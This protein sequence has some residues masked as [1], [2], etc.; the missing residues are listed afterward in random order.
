MV[1][2]KDEPTQAG[3]APAANTA[4]VAPAIALPKG[5]GAIRGIGEKFAANL[6]TGTAAMTV[7][8]ATSP[9]RAG[10][11]PRLEL[12]YD[13]GVGNG[14]FG[15]GWTLSLP[16]ITRKTD[17]GLPQYA[18]HD[19]L[20]VFLL[21]GAEDLAPVLVEAGGKWQPEVLPMRTVGG[22][23]YRIRRY[24]PRVEGLF[25][26]IE[27]W[28]NVANPT[29]TFWRSISKDN[30][31]TW[32]GRTAESRIADP[33]DATRI[34][35]W[36]ICESHD[37]RGNAIAYR[38]KA[39]NG[40]KVNL[41]AAH[42]QNRGP[43]DDA[44]RTANRYLKR[45]RYGNHTPYLPKL[46]GDQAWP[47][48][49]SDDPWY[50]EVVFDYGE[51]TADTAEETGPWDARPDAFSSYRSTFEVRTARLCQRVLM[52]HHIPDDPAPGT[53]KGYDGLVRS[54]KFTYEYEQDPQNARVPV[55]SK[56]V[57]ASQKGWQRK[58]GGGY[59]VAALPPVE[60]EYTDAAIG[61]ELRELD[62]ASAENLPAGIGGGYQWIDL[63]GEGLSGVLTEQA[64]GWFYKRNL[65][66]L[67]PV[68]NGDGA[69]IEAKLAPLELVATK[70]GFGLDG[71]TQFLDLAGDGRPDAV[72]FG[73]ATPGFYE[74]TEDAG[75]E[76]F[77]PFAALPAV[78]WADPNLKFLDM[79]G[80]GH[81]DLL[82]S[83]QDA[84]V[85]HRSLGEAGFDQAQRVSK[86]WDEERGPHLLFAD[87]EQSV[88]LAD[89]SGDG[90]TDIVRVRNGEVCYWPNL[91]YGRF[92]AKI[93]MDNSPL[94]DRPEQFDQR[95]VRLAD[96]DGSG[97]TD[98][99]YLHS[100]GVRVYFNQSGNNWSGPTSVDALP[101]LDNVAGVQVLDLLG[102][103]TACLVWSSP[104]PGDAPRTLRYLDLLGGEKPHLLKKVTNNLGG[105]T[106]ISYAASTKFYLLDRDAGRPWVTKLPFPVHCVERVTVHDKW[107]GT[108]FTTTYSYHHG[109][110]DGAEREFRGFGRVEQVDAEAYGK[111]AEGNKKSPF[112][113][114]DL[115]LYQP[116]VKTVTW[117]HT[118]A[119]LDRATILGHYRDEYFPNGFEAQMPGQQVLG[120]FRE[121]A[122]PEPDLRGADLTPD[123]WREA[124]RA[125]K[126][127]VL[128]QEIYE[129]DVDAHAKGEEK[130]VKLFSAAEH[131]CRI[132]RL[133]PQGP[134]PHAVFLVTESEALT[135][136]YELD[137]C[138]GGV[139]LETLAPDPRISHT[140]NLD[141]DEYGNIRQ[142]VAAAY[143][144]TGKLVDPNLKNGSQALAQHVQS[145][146]H[147]AYTETRYTNDVSTA[148]S[149]DRDSHRLRLP[150]EVRTYE[151]TGGL[152][153]VKTPE[154]NGGA[155]P[156]AVADR[157]FTP[158]ELLAYRLSERYQ[159]AG[160]EVQELGYHELPDGTTVQK[161]LVEHARSLFFKESLDGPEPF[162][163]LNR[164]ALP[165]ESYKLALTG[166][167]LDAV[168]GDKLDAPVRAA[169]GDKAK[170]GYLS[171]ND[172]T[173]RLGADTA[174]QFWIC[175]GVAGFNADAADHFYLPEHYTDPF[176]NP[177]LL[178]YDGRDL[179][180]QSST[181]ALG[182][183]TEVTDFDFRVLRPRRLK[184]INGNFSEVRF[185]VLGMPAALAL[186][187][188]GLVGPGA[189]GDN[190][191]GLDDASA[192]INPDG[193]NRA[194]FF[195]T[196]D[197]TPAA[198]K[199]FLQGATARHLYYFGEVHAGDQVVWGQHP[200]CAAGIR[201]EQH[202]AAN[203]DSPV[204]TAFEYSD[205][206]GNP[207]VKKVQAE[208]ATPGG[209]LRWVASGKTVLNN[210][211]KPVKQFEPAFSPPAIGHRYNGEEAALETGVTLVTYYDAAGRVVRT[212]A[213]DG[214][215]T[216]VEFSPW[217]VAHFD[218]N[219]TV[220]EDGNA[221]FAAKSAP[222]APAADRRAA[223]LAAGHANTP[224][225][226]VLDSLGR[227]VL[228]IS[229]NRTGPAAAP[230]DEKLVTFSKLDA[231]GK[232]LWVQDARGNRV[233]QYLRPPLPEGPKAFD[234]PQNLQPQGF[235]PCY[236]IAGNLLFQHGMD[237][238][239]R[240]MLNDAAGKPIYAWNSRGFISHVEYDKLHRPTGSFVT[241]TGDTT[242]IGSPRN[243]ALPPDP[244]RQFEKIVYGED[245]AD[246]RKHNLRGK[247]YQQRDAAGVMTVEDY[248]FKGNALSS[249]REFVADYKQTPDW[250]QAAPL[251]P[252]AFVT[253]TQFDALGRPVSITTPDGSTHRPHFNEASLLEKVEVNLRGEQEAGAPKWTP[254]VT[255]IDYNAKAQRERIEYANGATTTYEY[256]PQTFRLIHLKTTR[257]DDPDATASALFARRDTVQDLR[258][259]YDP[260]G[261][262]TRIADR[263]H[264]TV[265]CDNQQIDAASDYA[266]DALYRLIAASGRERAAA[267][268]YTWDDTANRI[269]M[270]PG[271]NGA[272]GC[273]VETYE[274][275]A[276]GNIQRMVHHDGGNA[277][278][279]GAVTW[280]R[281]Y[282]YD[283]AN[284]RLLATS[285]PGDA[286]GVFGAP[287]AYDSHGNTTRMSH[288]PLMRW[289]F[290][291]Q[292]AATSQQ[293]V[294]AGTPETTYYVYDGAG[295]R[296]RKVT[297]RQAGA[298]QTPARSKERIYLGGCE[299]YREYGN[300]GVG[301]AR[302]T[303]HVMDDK[304]R[305]ALVET[306]T[307]ENG[308]PI[309]APAPAV[310]YQLANHLGSGSLELDGQGQVISYEEYTP[311]GSTAY[312]AARNA[313]E[314]S[315]KR[316]RYTGKERDEETGFTYHG[317]R[318][319][320]PW[321]GRWVSCDPIGLA[322][323]PNLYAYVGN[324]P[325]NKTDPT[326]QQEKKEG[327]PNKKTDPVE[328]KKY[329]PCGD[330]L[331][332]GV[333]DCPS[334]FGAKNPDTVDSVG[335]PA[336][337]MTD[338]QRRKEGRP[339]ATAGAAPPEEARQGKVLAGPGAKEL[340]MAKKD[341]KQGVK[342][343]IFDATIGRFVLTPLEFVAPTSETTQFVAGLRP[344]TNS[345]IARYVA[346]ATS[347]VA[348]I[349]VDIALSAALQGIGDQ[350]TKGL[351]LE[352]PDAR[353]KITTDGGKPTVS[354]G[355]DAPTFG[356]RA[357]ASPTPLNPLELK[358]G[359]G[360][361]AVA[362]TPGGPL[363]M[364][365]L[366]DTATGVYQYRSATGQPLSPHFRDMFGTPGSYYATHAEAKAFFLNP[367]AASVT[368]SKPPCIG[369]IQ[370]FKA[371]SQL[372]NRPIQIHAPT[373]AG[374][375][376]WTFQN[377]QAWATPFIGSF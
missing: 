160:S 332:A 259:T 364:S 126:G 169:L 17:K 278:L 110:F 284:N 156:P 265:F 162:G 213:P 114:D 90:L 326:G 206:M 166:P 333:G 225:V 338:E 13:S 12:A 346:G 157:Y 25:A 188:K 300:G 35:S 163:T 137:L 57:S 261:N 106:E 299:F 296:V 86:P 124:L 84:F 82:I 88:Y 241:A 374:P 128:R 285:L 245:Q 146:V 228:Q 272:L 133:Q 183:R 227:D 324:G 97:T 159:A 200:P 305:I 54:T 347:Q 28:T 85:W 144:R 327:D 56:L 175:S 117:Y 315:L 108:R 317:A 262:I 337:T 49:P 254:F 153:G 242:L 16:A 78:D 172:L 2:V 103:G 295:Q 151:L 376:T 131:N 290:R 87:R 310:R 257:P 71:G 205:G 220:L 93:T 59:L 73:G 270:P 149:G 20:D 89:V 268:Q 120:D 207:L 62:A 271:D 231:E 11:G 341:S 314:V 75:W 328:E 323:G 164:L 18:D 352:P 219:D 99:L 9:G 105:E 107:R 67:N 282:Q 36:L 246:D 359:P 44:G 306:K 342:A 362:G 334:V 372:L 141:I 211:G 177:T 91:G 229:H 313:A 102:N 196:N 319:C 139:P 233:M 251:E 348:S 279:P 101:A 274:Y 161:R 52:F 312:Q 10:F 136:H 41:A 263:A 171:G 230:A 269:P 119:Y 130:P 190:L 356:F 192:A 76:P 83:E 40:D 64:G 66:P 224:T 345:P 155:L 216:R 77:V 37:D 208:P 165:Y 4:P 142:A 275:D 292:L 243:P 368:V 214:A 61:A 143:G 132:Q 260:S 30:V 174:G 65:S 193:D 367:S 46:A 247:P 336:Y 373:T 27:R 291:D 127:M 283:D 343:G 276:A 170:C 167:L 58:P 51:H 301:L 302:E 116:P 189:E 111:F 187:G 94:F 294:N 138:A 47:Q 29:D 202:A 168:F 38:Y 250:A 72:R 340:Q 74:R 354:L 244:P 311:Y 152:V 267:G 19:G 363:V 360:S 68:G 355:P 70:P 195:V 134:N 280:N 79:D 69:H 147:L 253:R 252:A 191:A 113:T 14:P 212:E 198:A 248:D 104:L 234:D 96:V 176:G 55:Y 158:D 154:Q 249:K 309:A 329:P 371:E 217:H 236:D 125:C 264:K 50:F 43:R 135:Y 185:D 330:E 215:V 204:Q 370:G 318:Y 210:K 353:F 98:I 366:D 351:K 33:A 48:L 307:R 140:L 266:Y 173:D 277:D 288:L 181:D 7:P 223:S 325:I 115:T 194:A 358:G 31:T 129:L 238:G 218:A 80:D 26:R 24:R 209:P 34:F 255:N 42:Q 201:R 221:W 222:G 226:T 349:L 150:C 331:D 184:D 289:D 281:R 297:E 92:G 8:I 357:N 180:L 81:A 182:S 308:N 239:D 63:D 203:A 286:D 298:G 258:Y 112:I 123:E 148:G 240:W 109:Y 145:R 53:Q 1:Q 15:L 178:N 45:V 186:S 179:I 316:Y 6:V 369:C 361:K 321:L 32:Y 237:G 232:P 23:A 118:G 197:Y 304:Q 39:E 100:D 95:R 335:D 365:G 322:A 121:N 350:M 235:A 21:S 320:A 303:L 199:G 377:G 5:G 60:F 293:V 344:K 122:L 273:Y 256:D 339:L 3:N 22:E 287:H 375:A